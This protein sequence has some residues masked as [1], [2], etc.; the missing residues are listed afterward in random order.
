I[1]GEMLLAVSLIDDLSQLAKF[2]QW[3][4]IGKNR[5][6]GILSSGVGNV[7][8]QRNFP[9]EIR[10]LLRSVAHPKSG[11]VIGRTYRL[12]QVAVTHDR[13]QYHLPLRIAEIVRL[14]Q[15]DPIADVHLPCLAPA[16]RSPDQMVAGEIEGGP[17][18]ASTSA[19][20]FYP[21]VQEFLSGPVIEPV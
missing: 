8:Q 10:R 14:R 11:A 18:M 6:L 1:P 17:A 13:A 21:E 15:H 12:R 3:R 20:S 19:R 9:F 5:T 16:A 2:S 7:S 4:E